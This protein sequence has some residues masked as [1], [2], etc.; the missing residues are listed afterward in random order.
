MLVLRVQRLSAR[1]RRSIASS[2]PA[3]TTLAPTPGAEADLVLGEAAAQA[4]H[5]FRE[6]SSLRTSQ[7]HLRRR[8][9]CRWMLLEYC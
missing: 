1:T 6:K 3:V 2:S 8:V 4:L 5:S 7:I 9:E